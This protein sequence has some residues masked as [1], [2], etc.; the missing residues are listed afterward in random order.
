[1]MQCVHVYV[2]RTSPPT[3]GYSVTNSSIHLAVLIIV[4]LLVLCAMAYAVVL[5]VLN[6]VWR[7]NK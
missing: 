2:G 4:G 3:S 5:L 1:M 6:I 7:E